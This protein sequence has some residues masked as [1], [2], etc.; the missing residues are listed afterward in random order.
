MKNIPITFYCLTFFLLVMSGCSDSKK[1]ST[2]T[3]GIVGDIMLG[4]MTNQ[5]MN[6]KGAR[7]IWGNL[8]DLLYTTDLNL[9]NLETTFT[10]STSAIP[11][12]F[13]FKADPKNVRALQEAQFDVVNTAN[14]HILDFDIQGLQET[15]QTLD[16]AN[17]LHTG[18]GMNIEQAQKPVII[19]KNDIRIGIIGFTDNEPTWQAA[20]AKPGTNYI[21][22]DSPQPAIE[23]IKKLRPK[24]DLLILSIHWGQTCD[25]ILRPNLKASRM[26]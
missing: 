15:V 24:V 19:T 6:A 10:I 25:N 7:Y 20:A 8:S 9:G 14:N 21:S 3:I 16:I 5:V 23:Q 1:S 13:N 17:I 22:V 4:R 11:K 12:V 26:R 18:A 2:I